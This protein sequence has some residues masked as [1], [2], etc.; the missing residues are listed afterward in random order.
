MTALRGAPV[1]AG[2]VPA[3]VSTLIV[4]AL[5]AVVTVAGCRA[6]RETAAPAGFE[7]R[8]TPPEDQPWVFVLGVAQDGGAPQAG[9]SG[10]PAWRDPSERR[11]VVCLALVDPRTS[12]RWIFEATP[13]FKEQWYRLD[14]AT[15]VPPG[16]G[17]NHEPPAR[18]RRDLDGIFLTHAHAGH[19]TGLWQLGHEST[20]SRG[21]PVWAMPRMAEFLE[22]NG[23][24]SQL[25][26]YENIMLSP[27]EDGTPIHLADDLRVTPFLVP[28]RQEYSEVVGFRIDGPERSVVFLPDIDSWEAWDRL[29]TRI[30]D[31][32]TDVD[33]A[34][35]DATFFDD[36]EIPGRDMS[37]F[38]HPFV[39]VSMDRLGHLDAQNRQKVRF[40]HVN[41]TNPI[42][43]SESE[44]SAEVRSR[45][46]R[47]AREGEVVSLGRGARI[48]DRRAKLDPAN[49]PK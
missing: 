21:I 32:V 24:W 5:L 28:H 9:D 48:A 13:D 33:V 43:D 27:L 8:P 46:F 31:V 10:H 2:L 44:A 26:R 17:A 12:K 11:L 37:G 30:E 29:G 20:G 4:A 41:H 15:P 36:G 22:T 7:P 38:P 18:T 49:R 14:R 6:A 45:G 23:P 39:R 40:I 19:Y 47:I 1:S 16:Q 3:L 34:Y 42:L 25:V 35:V